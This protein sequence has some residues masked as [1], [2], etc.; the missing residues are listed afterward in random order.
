LL[1]RGLQAAAAHDL[2][3]PA[4][5]LIEDRSFWEHQA[6]GL[7][8]FAA[9]DLFRV[10]RLPLAFEELLV[11][12]TRAHITPL[13]PLLSDESQFYLLT[14]GLGGVQLFQ[15][16]QHGLNPVALHGVPASLPDALAYDEFAKQPQFHPGIP[17]RGGE[18]GAIFHGQGARDGTI[19]KEETLRY[20]QQVD[21]GVRHAL[22]AEHDPLLLA[23]I[24]YLL[25]IYRA[26]NTY[27]QLA[28]D[29]IA[30]NPDDLRPEELHAR[31]CAI[32]AQRSGHERA[33]AID[34]F[35]SFAGTS[36]AQASRYLRT[37][38]PAAQEGRIATLFVAD[39]QRRWGTFDPATGALALHDAAQPR[40]TELVDFATIQT[41]LHG[42]TVYTVA[43][44]QLSEAAPL[45]AILRY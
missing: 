31:A 36:P 25:P 7:V 41:I 32:V 22:H 6:V 13:L 29:D 34:R 38:V 44:E 14:L 4:Y 3:T 5:Q 8:L 45:A 17:G 2:L 26:A 30:I 12:D 24:A 43:P 37:I 20:F 27:P 33:E 39:G 19:V 35:R 21:R 23:G 28:A 11:V 1:A 40:D 16:T 42:G 10:Y 15:G 9:A 18:R